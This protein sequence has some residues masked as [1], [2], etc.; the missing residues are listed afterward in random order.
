MSKRTWTNEQLIE[1]VKESATYMEVA[2]KLGLTNYGANSKTIK[3]YITELNLSI[4]H[5][6]SM[7]E[8]LKLARAQIKKKSLDEIFSVNN[9]DRKYIKR[10]VIEHKLLTYECAKCH[11]TEWQGEQLSLHLDHINGIN[12][13]NR[14]ENLRF[15]CP[16]CHS[17]TDT[18]CAN[19]MRQQEPKRCIDCNQPIC[20]DATRCKNC[21]IL[22][23]RTKI[24]WPSIIELE[25]MVMELGYRGT[26]KKLGVTDSAVKKRIKNYG[27]PGGT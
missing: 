7:G 22:Q 25:N 26:G 21:A 6:L 20:N 11:I 10:V 3:K 13:D 23:P 17:L 14:L 18:Y 1:A 27:E 9:V 5:F 24:E 16:N 15:L 2:R 19:N 8:Q 12:N 4:E